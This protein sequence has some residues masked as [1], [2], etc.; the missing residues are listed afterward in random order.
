MDTAAEIRD[1]EPLS[2]GGSQDDPD[3]FFNVPVIFG[4]G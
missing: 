1:H 3:G 2:F 4:I